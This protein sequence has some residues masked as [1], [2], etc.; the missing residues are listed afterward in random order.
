MR[1]LHRPE[2]CT[3][4]LDQILIKFT[5]GAPVA[6]A[7]FGLQADANHPASNIFLKCP[8]NFVSSWNLRRLIEASR[9]NRFQACALTA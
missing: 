2:N 1:C 3:R 9:R 7:A 6:R 8:Q 4:N 5:Q